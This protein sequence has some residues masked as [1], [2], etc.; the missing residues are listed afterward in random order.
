MSTA[1]RHDVTRLSEEDLYLFAEGTHSRLYEKLGAH[2]MK[3]DDTEGTYFAVWAPNAE[4]VS[5]VGDFNGWDRKAHPLARRGTCG[6]WEG[7]VPG[8]GHGTV[9]KYCIV[10]R[11][12]GYVVE[13]ADPFAFRAETPPQ[14]ASIVWN[15]ETLPRRSQQ[16]R[17][18]VAHDK[19]VSIYEVH[20]G[21][22]RRVKEEK[23]RPYTYRELAKELPEYALRMGF[24]HVEFLPVMEHPFGGSWGYQVTGFFAP[25]S[26][27]GTPEDFAALV[28]ALHD[29]GIGVILDWVPSHFPSDE[30]G[31]GYFDG[32]YLYEHADPRKGFHPDWKSLIFNY[33]RGE[34]VSFLIS[35]AH[36]WLDRYRADALR[37]DA[38]ASMLYLDYSRKHGE[39][40]PNKYG[41]RE[42]LE[43]IAFLRRLNES[44]GRTFPHAFTIAEESTSW[45]MVSRPAYVGGLGFAYKWDMGWMHDTLEYMSSDP[46][47]RK[48]IHN[49]LTFRM[50][51][52]F[53]ENFVL[54]LSHDE[55]VHLKGS[56][57]G[58]MKGDE[59]QR[60]ANLRSLYAYFWTQPG[61]KLLFMGGEIAQKGEWAHEGQLDWQ[62]LETG[63]YHI[64]I[65][66]LVQAL[67]R[68]Y[69]E[70]SALH[71]LDTSPDGFQWID[72]NDADH[73]V[74]VFFRRARSTDAIVIAAF[75]FTPVPRKKYRI[76]L[77]RGGRYH[78]LL[79]TDAVEFGGAGMTGGGDFLAETR[80]HHN[81]PHSAEITIPP[82]GAVFYHHAGL[83]VSEKPLGAT[84]LG[85]ERT[86]FRVWAPIAERVDVVLQSPL[87][88]RVSLSR[89]DHG[90]WHGVVDGVL[91]GA[92]YFYDLGTGT[93]RPDPASRLQPDGVFGPSEVVPS[94]P[95]PAFGWSGRPLHDYVIYEVHI[96][97]FTREGTFDAA[98]RRLPELKELG[99]TA[100]EIMPVAAFPGRRNWGYDGVF[101]FAVHT[102]YGGPDALR[103]FATA[104]HALGLAVIL[105][106]VY[107]HL[108]P[109]GNHLAEFGPYFS[110]YHRTP[111]GPAV[112]MDGPHSDDVRRLFIESAL[113]FVTHIGIDALRLDAVNSLVDGS[114]HTFLEEFGEALHRRGAELGRPI[115]LIAESDDNDPRLIKPQSQGGQ[116]LDA[117]WNDDFH[118][119]LEAVLTGER[120]GALVDHGP[121]E[122]LAKALRE[123]F[124]FTGQYSQYKRRR[125]GR[126]GADLDP[127]SMVVFAQNHDT[128]GNRPSG[129]RLSQRITFDQQK[130]AA[131]M[132]LLSP[133]VPLIF[134]GE[135]YG[136]KA[137]FPYFTHF[138]D[139]ELNESVALGRQKEM[140]RLGFTQTP[141][142]PENEAVFESA[143]LD[144]NLRTQKNHALLPAWYQELLRIRREYPA[145]A[146]GRN[147]QATAFEEDRVLFVRRWVDKSEM[148]LVFHFSDKPVDID[149]PIPAGTYKMVVTSQDPRFGGIALGTTADMI[150]SGSVRLTCGA[151]ESVVYTRV[152]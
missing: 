87:E 69:Q 143:F 10:S 61:K 46:I 85:D 22:F 83:A 90:Y 21:S 57:L 8:I 42:N 41:G 89:E 91:P 43:A 37:V 84:Y 4:R 12:N 119:A 54:P 136:E 121:V 34:V 29:A 32:T 78:E 33:G 117:V 3:A 92:R 98:I 146:Q 125:H 134:M 80:Q 35:S 130:L 114:P 24:T 127:R 88:R 138:D 116:G 7:F 111:W 59:W 6:I 142:R 30:H 64:G 38:V 128:V 70:K 48:F 13:K 45:P 95:D 129:D 25:T 147:C 66:K 122:H 131:A 47:F 110:E 75:N 81:R 94:V 67:N 52:A 58:K 55:V 62:A 99:I 123:N 31:L 145:L 141:P 105:D 93:L 135:E 86:G 97:T 108:G 149:L 139:A 124:V 23:N 63:P 68:L 132:V 19:P 60:F 26:R 18:A 133:F 107:N 118:R 72:C 49:K 76:G 103:R 144:W 39:W 56:L 150:S 77:P 11:L 137:P 152:R 120:K 5:V 148:V 15:L 17:Y 113:Y 28:D 71:E 101:P 126:S 9:Y 65:Q 96:G 140:T 14:T 115:H 109:E 79:S 27:Y 104:C 51:Y 16:T 73:S 82:L 100:I 36:F 106:V 112:N 74:V 20:V 44:I 53:S 151:F 1:V 2:V 102:G 40:E 50:M